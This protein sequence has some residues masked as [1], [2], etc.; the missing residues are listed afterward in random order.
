VQVSM[1]LVDPLTFGPAAAYDAVASRAAVAGAEL[2]GLVPAPALDAIPRDRWPEL[3]LD[4]SRTIQAR[5]EEAGLD[6][7]STGR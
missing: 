1:N 3:D 5:L 7:G 4:G 6:G 2:V